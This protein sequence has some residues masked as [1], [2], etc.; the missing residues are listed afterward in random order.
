MR[1]VWVAHGRTPPGERDGADHHVID[2]LHELEALLA[3]A[4]V[5]RQVVKK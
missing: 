4:G 1:A 5:V 2:A 3:S